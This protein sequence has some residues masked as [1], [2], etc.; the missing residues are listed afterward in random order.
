MQMLKRSPT[1]KPRAITVSA[2]DD[3][4]DNLR[5]HAVFAGGNLVALS[6]V[7]QERLV[8]YQTVAKFRPAAHV[9][10]IDCSGLK[11]ILEETLET[12]YLYCFEKPPGQKKRRDHLQ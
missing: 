10:S 5:A 12:L 8:S 4:T 3:C 7:Q 2:E 9:D 11:K 1:I 6:Q